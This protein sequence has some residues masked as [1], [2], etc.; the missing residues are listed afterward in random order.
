MAVSE[1]INRRIE[2]MA[3]GWKNIDRKNSF[4]GVCHLLSSSMYC[5]VYKDFLILRL[6][7]E[8]VRWVAAYPF[9]KPLGITGKSMQG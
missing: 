2:N 3:A 7:E 8:T 1:E 5:R 4:G 6:G 9:V